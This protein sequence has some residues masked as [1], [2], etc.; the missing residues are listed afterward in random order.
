MGPEVAP[1]IVLERL[2]RAVDHRRKADELVEQL[3][4]DARRQGIPWHRIGDA[5]GVTTQ[6]AWAKYHDLVPAKP[7]RSR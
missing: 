3:V 6:A 2:E 5:L 4:A 7:R 1:M